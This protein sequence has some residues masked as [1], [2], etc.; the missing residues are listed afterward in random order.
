MGSAARNGQPMP[1]TSVTA[2]YPPSMP[3]A[4]CARLMKFIIPSVT[5]SPTDR[6]NSSMP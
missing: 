3:K 5:D 2:T 6:R 1:F 4:Q